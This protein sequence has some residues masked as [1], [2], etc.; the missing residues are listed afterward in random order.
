MPN[1]T[2]ILHTLKK[3]YLKERKIPIS[4]IFKA[5]ISWYVS[6][7]ILYT[8]ISMYFEA[9]SWLLCIQIQVFGITIIVVLTIL[10]VYFV[11]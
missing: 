10:S 5:I 2:I 7:Y 4:G 3:L 1:G 9:R 8:Y 11:F 6:M